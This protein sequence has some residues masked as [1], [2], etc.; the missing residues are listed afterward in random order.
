MFHIVYFTLGKRWYDRSFLKIEENLFGY[1]F[2]WITK[3][4]ANEEGNVSS[5]FSY[6]SYWYLLIFNYS[7]SFLNLFGL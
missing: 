2:S 3:H 1:F 7:Y 5:I 6:I 4:F